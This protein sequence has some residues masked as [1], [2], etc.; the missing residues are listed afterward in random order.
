MNHRINNKRFNTLIRA[1]PLFLCLLWPGLTPA[2]VEES[3]VINDDLEIPIMRY[4]AFADDAPI[5]LW[6]PSS[7]GMSNKQAITAGALGDLDIETW[8]VDLHTAY[9]VDTGR[10]SVQHFRAQDIADL[11]RAAAAR[12]SQKVY[13]MA[14]DRVAKPALEGIAL[15]QQQV[16]QSGQDSAVGGVIL[17]HPNLSYPAIE[18]G[19]PVR[20]IPVAHNS[21][22]P[23]YFI[24]P[25]ISTRQWRSLE[26]Q[27]VLQAGG[28]PVFMHSM[29]GVQAGFHMRPN[30]DL[31]DVDLLQRARLPDDLKRAIKLL[32]LQ[33]A[34][35]PPKT[36]AAESKPEKPKR[37]YGLN[38]LNR[39]TA[40]PL[41]L[42]NL[43]S[44][45][46]EVD[47]ADNKLSLVSFWASWCE[48][49]IK[50]LPSLKRLH[51]DYFDK[52][53]RIIT[54]NIGETTQ[55]IHKAVDTFS[56]NTYTNLRDPEGVAMNAWN[57]YGYP[58]NFLITRNGTMHYGSIGG[59]EWDQPEVRNIID[60]LL[61]Y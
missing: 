21:T 2:Q 13:L 45:L 29:P 38:K 16:A 35:A 50:E 46:I 39:Q 10:S 23:V 36:V 58:S 41:A 42:E 54:V 31:N 48:P 28:S 56:M 32:S 26:L 34:V 27:K 6:L 24:Q 8:I 52:G 18:P 37:Q 55:D 53:L 40:L 33:A 3:I 25:S 11:I 43:N 7:R 1:F 44:Q 61:N 15:Y 9:F 19:K 22:I 4:E 59:V 57:V 14:T 51:D 49:C 12:T 47:Y 5:V 30:E 60:T 17:F 20:Y